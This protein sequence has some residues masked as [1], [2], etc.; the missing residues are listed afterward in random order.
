MKNISL[1]LQNS[2]LLAVIGPVGSGKSSVINLLLKELPY[3]SGKMNITGK[4]SYSSQEPWLFSGSVRQ[5]ILF[6]EKFNEERYLKVIDICAL[7][8]DFAQFPHGDKTLV[9]EKGKSLSGGQKARI[10]LARCVYKIADIYLLDDP[11][12]AVDA[13]V[14]KHLYEN[15][16][17]EF[18]SNK[19]CVLVTH[20]LQ[21]LKN[22][23]NI[24]IMQDGE[25]QIQG[26]YKELQTSGVDFAKLL[27]EFNIE[28]IDEKD[29]KVKS[30]QNSEMEDD[31]ED[32]DQ[33]MEKEKQET[34]TIP[35]SIYWAYLRA[36]GGKFSIFL[37]VFS[38]IFCQIV[39]N[40]G[41]YYV[42]YW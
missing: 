15:C 22:A 11:L 34:G 13:N 33:M 29:K 12:S 2:Q 1:K 14:G 7:K 9:G 10:N 21:Y 20:Q 41:E 38:F 3:K 26:N 16:I 37:L 32:E 18:L 40:G 8:S 36:G 4:I 35:M 5:N 28:E 19:L 42:T 39:A 27:E 17:R 25:I 24:I 23:D 31:K 30:R 6:G